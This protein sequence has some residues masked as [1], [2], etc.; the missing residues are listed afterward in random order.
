M[1]SSPP[2]SLLLLPPSVRVSVGTQ[3][4]TEE[5]REGGEAVMVGEQLWLPITAT[6]LATERGAPPEPGGGS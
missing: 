6:L 3:E 2:P 4:E 1:T 5:E